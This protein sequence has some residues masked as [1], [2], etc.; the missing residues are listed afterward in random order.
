VPRVVRPSLKVS[1]GHRGGE[2]DRLAEG[3]GVFDDARLV[4][5]AF[6]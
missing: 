3:A 6:A 2:G 4:A 1:W 5:G